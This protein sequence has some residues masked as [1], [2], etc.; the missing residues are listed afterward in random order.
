MPNIV[1]EISTTSIEKWVIIDLL[2]NVDE[3]SSNFDI[4]SLMDRNDQNCYAI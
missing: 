2:R 3:S 1:Q 4:P